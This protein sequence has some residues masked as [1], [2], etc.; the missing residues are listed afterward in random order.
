MSKDGASKASKLFRLMH[1]PRAS[2]RGS[3]RRTEIERQIIHGIVEVE[4]HTTIANLLCL[5]LVAMAAAALPF[6]EAYVVPLLLRLAIMAN[7]KLTF[8]AMRRNLA[9][10]GDHSR[11]FRRLVFALAI[12]GMAWGA[13]LLPLIFYSDPHPARLLAAGGTLIG[14]SVIVSLLSPHMTLSLAFTGGVAAVVAVGLVL[15]NTYENN[16]LALAGLAGLC[17]I[18]VA[19]SRATA[20]GQQRSAEL[21]VENAKIGTVL[22]QALEKA[23]FLAE[24]DPL[25]G[26][27]N[28]RALF[29]LAG[30]LT[31]Y[32]IRHVLILDLDHF[33]AINDRHGHAVGDEVL[34]AA[35]RVLS[36]T[37]AQLGEGNAVAARIGGEE[38]AMVIDTDELGLARLAAERIRHAI[39]Q[40]GGQRGGEGLVT[41][42][43]VG[44]AEWLPQD[45]LGVA[46]NLADGA[47]YRAKQGGRNRVV[48]AEATACVDGHTA[49]RF[50]A[51]T[52]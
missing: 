4:R 33:K 50:R 37:A 6:R 52:R 34:V 9:R 24:R 30:R 44:I 49:D 43:S 17:T 16:A 47:L 23:R 11:T 10:G 19:Y 46:L 48:I 7:T 39:A 20:I 51:A 38:F 5:A 3:L 40:I 12:G 21:F 28:R 1:L 27:H 14:L 45:E 32:R 26:L 8:E 15:S 25:T 18:F 2:P 42:A 13:T 22:A 36:S 31:D 35:G 29:D 41:S